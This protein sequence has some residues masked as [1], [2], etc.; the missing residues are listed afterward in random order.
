MPWLPL[1]LV[2]NM[3]LS[4]FPLL[5]VVSGRHSWLSLFVVVSDWVSRLPLLV[6]VSGWLS[7]LSLFL[8]AIIR[9][10]YGLVVVVALVSGCPCWRT[11]LLVV[12]GGCCGCPSFWLLVLLTCSPKSCRL[13]RNQKRSSSGFSHTWTLRKRTRSGTIPNWRGTVKLDVVFLLQIMDKRGQNW[14]VP[15]FKKTR[16]LQIQF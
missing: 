15:Q 16:S 13:C 3:E 7:W 12:A 8:V 5:V 4:W 9:F 2:G 1:W 10:C 6:V 11:S 14:R